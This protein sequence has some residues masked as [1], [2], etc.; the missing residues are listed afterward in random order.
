M[1]QSRV[2]SLSATVIRVAAAGAG[3]ALGGP[4]VGALTGFIGHLLS[5]P[6]AEVVQSYAEKFGD[7]AGEK[8][9]ELGGDALAEKIGDCPSNLESLYREA[10]QRSLEQVHPRELSPF[11]DGAHC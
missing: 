6:A 1:N 4:L 10:L 2:H 9:L 11:E 5:G 3:T 8:L 7:K